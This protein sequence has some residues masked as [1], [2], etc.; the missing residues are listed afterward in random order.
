MKQTLDPLNLPLL[1]LLRFSEALLPLAPGT[2]NTVSP[3]RIQLQIQN[4]QPRNPKPE[5]PN[6]S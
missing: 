1:T 2:R 6:I 4:I 3:L 5:T